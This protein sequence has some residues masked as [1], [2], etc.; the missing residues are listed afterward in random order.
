[1]YGIVYAIARG[2]LVL[3]YRGGRVT[4]ECVLKVIRS[5]HT[6]SAY[7]NRNNIIA[8]IYSLTL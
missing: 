5:T 6:F 8:G 3:G 7:D 2:M 4:L 1:M